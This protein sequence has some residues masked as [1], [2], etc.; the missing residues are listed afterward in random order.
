MLRVWVVVALFA[1]VTVARSRQVGIPLRDPHG[2]ILRS[3]L[4]IS[5]AL[6]VVLALLDAVVRTRRRGVALSQVGTVLRDRWPLRRL[7]LA[8]SGLLAYHAVY[9]C[10][11]N[12]KSWDVLNRPRDAM[13]LRWDSALFL[14]H[15]PAVLLHDLLGQHLAAY[16]LLGIYESF[17]WLVSV[18]FVSAIVLTDRVREGYV[19]IASAICV[20]ILGVSCYYL[21]PSLGPFWSAPHDFAGLPHTMVQDTQ[22]RYLAQRAHLLAHP[23]AADAF[24]QVSAFASLHIGVTTVIMLMAHYYRLRTLTRLLV[25][26]LAGT[27]VATVYLGWHFVVDDIAGLLIGALA[28]C[29]GRLLVHPRQPP[30][31]WRPGPGRGSARARVRRTRPLL[32]GRRR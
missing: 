30:A 7:A 32:A 17:S 8:W 9:F 1:A 27:L 19:F 13:L 5:A 18:A 2:E 23:A 14:G 29:F 12:L 24:A 11:H 10:Y 31:P 3:R 16:L 15:S 20:W 28:V 22:V 6:F 4:A 26:Y 25:V 21:I